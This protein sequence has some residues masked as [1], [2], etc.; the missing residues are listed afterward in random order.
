[1]N[2]NELIETISTIVETKNI[3]KNGLTLLYKLDDK[4]HKSMNEAIYRKLNPFG[5]DFT[6]TDEFEVFIGGILIKFVKN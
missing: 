2:Y 5:D 6:P 4:D 1:M 3:Y